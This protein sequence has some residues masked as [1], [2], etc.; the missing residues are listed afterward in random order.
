MLFKH[1][2]HDRVKGRPG[3]SVRIL[4]KHDRLLCGYRSKK[5]KKLEVSLAK[6]RAVRVTQTYSTRLHS[7]L[8][9]R[10]PHLDILSEQSRNLYGCVTTAVAGQ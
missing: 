4:G 5:K 9:T 8:Y 10:L 2:I 6:G 3:H 1:E 7:C